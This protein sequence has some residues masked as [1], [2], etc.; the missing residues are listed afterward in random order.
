MS[1]PSQVWAV[2]TGAG[3][4]GSIGAAILRRLVQRE[5][6]LH[7]L[8]VGRRLPQLEEA[9]QLAISAPG[10][11]KGEERLHILKADIT[12]SDGLYKV[13]AAIPSNACVKYLI[14]S[15]AI[16]Q[17]IGPLT[18]IDR[19]TWHKFYATNVDAPLF[20]TQALIPSLK[21]CV[22]DNGT[23]ARVLHVGSVSAH[24]PTVG[25]VSF[26]TY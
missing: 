23:K 17:P 3:G 9:K 5:P 20:L 18:E 12:T 15:A 19:S 13:V 8:G 1:S 22:A 11:E 26:V 25:W 14:H 10:V 16:L 6:N 7:V 24:Q 21:R 4:S 2:I